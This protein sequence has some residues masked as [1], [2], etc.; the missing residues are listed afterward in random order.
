M[1]LSTTKTFQLLVAGLRL[2]SFPPASFLWPPSLLVRNAE[3]SGNVAGLK[4]ESR[5]HRLI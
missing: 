4:F 1:R 2:W 5:T 3:G